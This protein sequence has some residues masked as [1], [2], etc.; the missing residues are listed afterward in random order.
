VTVRYSNVLKVTNRGDG[1]AAVFTSGAEYKK[2]SAS[3]TYTRASAA[4]TAIIKDP[5]NH[6]YAAFV[7][8][9]PSFKNAYLSFGLRFEKNNLFKAVLN[10]R[11]GLTT[12]FDAKSMTVKPRIS[13]GKGITSPSY[14]ERFGQPQSLSTVVYANANIKPQSQQGFDY[15]LE[16]YDKKGRYEFEI[17]YY[18][19]ILKD[20]IGQEQLG[21]AAGDPNVTGFMYRNVAKV[22][23]L[24]WEFSGSYR[25]G[26]YNVQGTFSIMNTVVKD[27]TG[28]FILPQLRLAPGSR[29]VN[30]PRHTGGFNFTYNFFKLFGSTDKGAVS[31]NFTEVDGV[32]SLDIRNY[33][34]DVAY[35]R[36]AYI[37]GTFGY[38]VEYSPAF[39]VGLYADYNMASDWKFFIQG[40]NIFNSYKYEYWNEYPTHGAGWLF[41]FK[42][43]FSNKN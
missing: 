36:T 33:L 15:G 23:N 24:G 18:N 35:G 40:S 28:S 25:I 11:V 8:L 19:N 37:P 30:L 14:Q 31:V 1:L 7:Q 5:D 4:A 20:M 9:N 41:G 13:W 17:I 10:P 6:N 3:Q 22:A 39:R 21:P 38:P 16:V 27:S 26:R 12:N 43:K 42:Y 32:K 34:L 2:Y 29:L